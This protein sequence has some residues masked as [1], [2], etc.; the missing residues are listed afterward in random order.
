MKNLLRP[1][2]IGSSTLLERFDLGDS[3]HST[4]E[5]ELGTRQR[6]NRAKCE[7]WEPMS[8]PSVMC[9]GQEATPLGGF[10]GQLCSQSNKPRFAG[11]SLKTCA[12]SATR[13]LGEN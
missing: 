1:P 8:S 3:A 6:P 13:R 12:L 7:C 10:K 2:E 9:E 4:S 11:E 5:Q